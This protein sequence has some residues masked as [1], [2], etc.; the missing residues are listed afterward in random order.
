MSD[1][2]CIA[3]ASTS[4][5]GFAESHIVAGEEKIVLVMY[6]PG[7]HRVIIPLSINGASAVTEVLLAA[8]EEY[9]NNDETE[10]YA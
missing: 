8:L 1:H 9:E 5:G 2:R 4:S 3:V 7:E 6:Q 10:F